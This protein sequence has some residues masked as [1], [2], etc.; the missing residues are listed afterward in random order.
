M[1]PFSWGE[2]INYRRGVLHT[3]FINNNR[4]NQLGSYAIRPYA[5]K[6]DPIKKGSAFLQSLSILILF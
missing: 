6:S 4:P 2:K 3:P 5:T 1:N